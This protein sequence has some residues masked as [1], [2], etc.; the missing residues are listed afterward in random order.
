[1]ATFKEYTGQDLGGTYNTTYAST[2]LL[3]DALE[4]ACSTDPKVLAEVLHTTTFTD[5]EGKWGFQWPQASFDEKGRLKESASVIAQWQDGQM[6]AVWPEEFAAAKAVWPV[7]GW[8]ERVRR[9]DW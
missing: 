4:K 9:H 7:P 2:W 6:V 8:D 3:A 5:G 1:M